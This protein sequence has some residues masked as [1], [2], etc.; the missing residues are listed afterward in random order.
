VGWARDRFNAPRPPHLLIGARAERVRIEFAVAR[1]VQLCGQVVSQDSERPLARHRPPRAAPRAARTVLRRYASFMPAAPAPP[2]DRLHGPPR[3]REGVK[4]PVPASGAAR[5]PGRG[6][7]QRATA[8]AGPAYAAR[9]TRACGTPG[10]YARAPV[11]SAACAI[12]GRG[13]HSAATPYGAMS[14]RPGRGQ[15]HQPQAPQR[16]QTGRVDPSPARMGRALRC[17]CDAAGRR[18]QGGGPPAIASVGAPRPGLGP[19]ARGGFAQRS[20]G[21]LRAIGVTAELV[22]HSGGRGRGPLQELERLPVLVYRSAAPPNMAGADEAKPVAAEMTLD[23]VLVGVV[24]E[25]A[26]RRE[27]RGAVR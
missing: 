26:E 3:D 27:V 2:P 22:R 7:E 11:C 19:L 5:R 8:R 14:A 15:D 24:R 20:F 13:C 25:L 17:G 21:S 6:A 10:S 18:A 23:L 16:H 4:V 9:S 12:H 1:R